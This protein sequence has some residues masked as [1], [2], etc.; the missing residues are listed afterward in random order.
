MEKPTFILGVGAQ[1]AGTTWLYNQLNHCNFVN[2]GCLKEY[3]VWD[4]IYS[5]EMNSF[6]SIPKKNEIPAE[7]LRRL[8]QT[9]SGAYEQ[10]FSGLISDNVTI[11]GD[12][13]PSSSI[14]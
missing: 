13:T 4:A 9:N 10:Y 1:K 5:E 11:T 14:L 3:H 7:A 8:M 2:M 6:I 12:I